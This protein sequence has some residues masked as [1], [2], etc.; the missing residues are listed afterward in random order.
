M[1]NNMQMISC[2]CGYWY[3]TTT[4]CPTCNTIASNNYDNI[5]KIRKEKLQEMIDSRF[6]NVRRLKLEIKDLENELTSIETKGKEE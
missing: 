3:N 5:D 6:R 1:N 4:K 2:K